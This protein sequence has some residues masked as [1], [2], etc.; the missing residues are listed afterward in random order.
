MAVVVWSYSFTYIFTYLSQTLRPFYI[1]DCQITLTQLFGGGSKEKGENTDQDNL[2]N[3]DL[4]ADSKKEENIQSQT[5][6][7]EDK[8]DIAD[9]ISVIDAELDYE[10]EPDPVDHIHRVSW[11]KGAIVERQAPLCLASGAWSALTANKVGRN[12]PSPGSASSP[13]REL[14]SVS[15]PTSVSKY[16]CAWDALFSAD[17]TDDS[18]DDDSRIN[19]LL[20]LFEDEMGEES[21]SLEAPTFA[22]TQREGSSQASQFEGAVLSQRGESI[23]SSIEDSIMSNLTQLQSIEAACP[24]WRDNIRFALAHRG[25]AEIRQA[26]ER[27]QRSMQALQATKEKISLVWNRQEVV[28]KLFEMSLS[29]SLSRLEQPGEE[30][31]QNESTKETANLSKKEPASIQGK[32]SNRLSPVIE[33]D[34]LLSQSSW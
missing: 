33:C 19:Q 9:N 23:A 21:V 10:P 34:E 15:L 7:D 1:T 16:D 26:L 22:S 12:P 6:T 20:D 27:V 5:V 13:V 28:L 31:L 17:V 30:S 4:K 2:E 8:E 18:N 11:R 3:P 24:K 29:A 14:G 32:A 25:E